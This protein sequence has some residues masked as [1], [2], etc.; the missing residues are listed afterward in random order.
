MNPITWKKIAGEID[1]TYRAEG[2]NLVARKAAYG[3]EGAGWYLM[4]EK[5]N[6]MLDYA[7]GFRMVFPTLKRAQAAA[8]RTVDAGRGFQ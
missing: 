6:G 3:I 5:H 4:I 1:S 2:R 8:Q 7:Y